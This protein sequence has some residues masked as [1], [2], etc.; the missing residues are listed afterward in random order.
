MRQE[1]DDDTHAQRIC[2]INLASGYRGGERQTELLMR[3]LAARGWPQRLVVRNGSPLADRCRDI[4]GLEIRTVASN[5]LSAALAAR[6]S[7]LVHVHDGRSV[8]AGWLAK[9]VAGIPFVITRRI[10]HAE[11]RSFVRRRAW[12]ASDAIIAISQSIA[13]SIRVRHGVAPVCVVPSAHAG[14]PGGHS[15]HSKVLA[16]LDGKTI[17]GNVGALD[18][19]KGQDAIIEAARALR[20]SRPELHFVLVGEGRD[21]ERFRRAAAG[22]D[23]VEFT[24]FVE[25]VGDYLAAFDLFVFPSLQ[26]GLGS[27]LLDAMAFGLPIIASRVGGI[28]ELVQDRVNGL[29][30]APGRSDELV[31][32]LER[33]LDAPELMSSM[34]HAYEAIYRAIL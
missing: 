10:H 17:I 8:Y 18:H 2:H 27:T 16:D 5:P 21:G 30:I 32:A 19:S 26:E 7:A 24:G 25:N 12:Q 31:A 9:R 15:D 33:L 34:A 22:L 4:P 3:R 20:E 23:N 6:G 28:P 29:L 1:A 14:M 13:E 11:H